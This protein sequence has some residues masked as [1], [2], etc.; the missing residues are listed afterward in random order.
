MSGTIA[1]L[2]GA[3]LAGTAVANSAAN[4][5]AK[6]SAKTNASAPA[7]NTAK[8]STDTS[9]ASSASAPDAASK[10]SAAPGS[11]PKAASK[12]PASS[13]QDPMILE[14]GEEG[15]VFKSLTVTGEDLV[16]VEFERPELRLDL[17][18]RKAP[19]LEWGDA[20]GMLKE[21]SVDVVKPLIGLSAAE[22]SPF[23]C[24]PWL[25][26][27]RTG[28]VARFQ[29]KM[30][31]V[32]KWWLTIADS[33][34]DTLAVM[35]GKGNPPKE[36]S[37]DGRTRKGTVVSPGVTCSYV[38]EA[39]DRAGNRRSFVGPGFVLP[40]Y[41]VRDAVNEML[42][43]SGEDLGDPAALASSA[44]PPAIILE[45]ASWL[46]QISPTSGVIQVKVSARSFEEADR[47]SKAI[48]AAL[49][50]RVLGDPARIRASADVRAD[51]P[52][53]GTVTITAGLTPGATRSAS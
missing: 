23:L 50:K 39:L 47:L 1:I 30:E 51:L 14:G 2:A 42:L 37:W 49:Q 45:T 19:G 6:S 13:A 4:T 29:P 31:G 32:E 7:K 35:E 44:N 38:L 33:R 24:K 46:N 15:T 12:A 10:A 8:A 3:M 21:S 36:I 48:T 41:R 34:S 52:P 40:A 28:A 25:N 20:H 22:S 11:A 5:D 53:R 16:H 26:A 18:L 17:D 27:Y 9:K 43:F